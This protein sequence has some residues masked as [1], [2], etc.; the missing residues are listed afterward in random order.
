MSITL[1]PQDGYTLPDSVTVTMNGAT[2]TDGYT[3][4]N[5]VLTIDEVY[6]NTVIT[7]KGKGGSSGESTYKVSYDFYG[8]T[9]SK[10]ESNV[11]AGTS[12]SVKLTANDGYKLKSSKVSVA[13]DGKKVSGGYS[14]EQWSI[15]NRL[16]FRGYYYYSDS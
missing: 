4:E 8:V 5:G 16:G 6:G 13:V 10:G 9:A 15:D 1:T 12:F 3:Y 14:Y 11:K 7:A 2:L